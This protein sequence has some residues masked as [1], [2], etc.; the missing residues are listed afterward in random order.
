MND[1]VTLTF[2]EGIGRLTLARAEARNAIDPA[3]VEGLAEAL[4]KAAAHDGLRALLMRADGPAFSVGG[5]LRYMAPRV[6]QLAD[7]FSSMIGRF[8]EVLQ[9]IAELPVPVVCAAKGAV[10]GGALG[11]LWCSDLTIVAHSTTIAAGFLELGL[12]GD[13]G[14]TWWLPRL[15]GLQRARQLLLHHGPITGAQ[16]NEWGLVTRALP[17]DEVEADAERAVRALASRPAAAYAEIRALLARSFERDL[18]DGLGA[19]REAM[20]R[21]VSTGEA[22]ERIW[23]WR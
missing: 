8:H 1:R 4:D 22:R 5:D 2:E 21:T 3:M 19:E 18:A 6:D 7:E 20:I 17:E 13:G 9:R 10:A 11:L 15:V 23:R 14:S 12:S 16:A